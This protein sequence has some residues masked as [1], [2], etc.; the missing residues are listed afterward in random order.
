MKIPLTQHKA[1][2][3]LRNAIYLIENPEG[4]KYIGKCAKTQ[5]RFTY[6]LNLQTKNQKLLHESFLKYG[7][8]NHTVEILE[9]NLNKEIINER[10]IYWINHYDSFGSNGLNL[11][12][13]GDGSPR[14]KKV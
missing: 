9:F 12:C 11:T 3:N 4:Q 6:Y 8:E 10:E 7:L 1:A 13:G 5:K 14:S 2:I